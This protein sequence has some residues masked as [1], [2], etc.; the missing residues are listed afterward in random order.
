MAWRKLVPL[1]VYPLGV[2]S[3]AVV[4]LAGYRVWKLSNHSEVMLTK[5]SKQKFAWKDEEAH[6]SEAPIEKK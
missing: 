4:G 2:F 1:E 6:E 5:N 3:A